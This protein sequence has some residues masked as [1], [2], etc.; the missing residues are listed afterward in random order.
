MVEPIKNP[1]PG[2][3]NSAPNSV[4]GFSGGHTDNFFPGFPGDETS[5]GGSQWRKEIDEQCEQVTISGVCVDRCVTV[6]S[7]FQGTTLIDETSRVTQSSC[8]SKRQEAKQNQ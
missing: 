4:P 1:S 6:T 2:Y 7:I 5:A 3:E 8:L